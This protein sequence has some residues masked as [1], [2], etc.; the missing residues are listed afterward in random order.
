MWKMYCL[1]FSVVFSSEAKILAKTNYQ[2]NIGTKLLT[3]QFV[4]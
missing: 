1:I 4:S 2:E 3:L